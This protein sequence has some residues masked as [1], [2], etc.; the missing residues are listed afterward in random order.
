MTRTNYTPVRLTP[1]ERAALEAA[2]GA[3]GSTISDA[4]RAAV[5]AQY[6][7][8]GSKNENEGSTVFVQSTGAAPLVQS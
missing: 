6:M 7:T 8:P 4:L 1:N 5:W 3:R 2:A